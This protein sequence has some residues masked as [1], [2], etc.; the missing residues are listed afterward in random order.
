MVACM[1]MDKLVGGDSKHE[2]EK[3]QQQDL[4]EQ[5]ELSAEDVIIN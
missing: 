3:Q 5:R 4:Q 1:V 2:E